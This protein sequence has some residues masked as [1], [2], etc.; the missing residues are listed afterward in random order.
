[1]TITIIILHPPPSRC[2]IGIGDGGSWGQGPCNRRWRGFNVSG[3]LLAHLLFFI[4]GI[5]KDDDLV[6]AGQL[7]DIAV[8]VT[9][10]SPDKLLIPRGIRDETFLI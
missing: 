6:V 10:E 9:E 7:K 4:V 8:E 2:F 3:I 1:V 5:I